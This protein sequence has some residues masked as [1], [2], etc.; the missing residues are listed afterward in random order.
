M[1]VDA[2]EREP[3]V[4]FHHVP[5]HQREIDARL[6]NWGRWSLNGGMGT[7][8]SPMF[9]LYRSGD[10]WQ[11]D[12]AAAS[13]QPV[14]RTDAMRV[15]RAMTLLATPHRLALSW[16]YIRRNNPRRA[17]ISL[18]VGMQE[19]KVIIDEGRDCLVTFLA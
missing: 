12:Y 16:C 4:D 9:A 14:D 18:G 2:G 8:S 3:Y 5:E 1:T 11:R 15:Q 6:V 13:G 19:L 10:H 7:D 17:A